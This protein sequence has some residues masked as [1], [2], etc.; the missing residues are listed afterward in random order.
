MRI[1]GYKQFLEAV[2]GTE[3]VG[4]HMGPGYPSQ[5]NSP[6]KKIGMTD[7]IYS[8]LFDVVVHHDQYQD[9]YNQ[10]RKNLGQELLQEF[11]LENIDKVINF[12]QQKGVNIFENINQSNQD[13]IL[14][15]Q[16]IFQEL[17]IDGEFKIDIKK[18]RFYSTG[19]MWDYCLRLQKDVLK[20]DKLFFNFQEVK[21]EVGHF[22]SFLGE[23]YY[24]CLIEKARSR[25]KDAIDPLT[26]TDNDPNNT[27]LS[28]IEIVYKDPAYEK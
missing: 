25:G 19:L 26:Y 6:M 21:D 3:L 12:L 22:V 11:T 15:I 27:F 1:K 14:E 4:N 9:L 2:S 10:Y 28:S 13:E 16:D 20:T 17:I 18:N 5:D 23:R 7:V 24:N 8:E